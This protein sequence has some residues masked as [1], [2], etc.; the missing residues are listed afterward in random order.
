[1]NLGT[2]F[3]DNFSATQ[4]VILLMLLCSDVQDTAQQKS[5]PQSA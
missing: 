1:M 4:L 2:K 5:C 3:Y